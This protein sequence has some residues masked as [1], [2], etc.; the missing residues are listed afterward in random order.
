MEDLKRGRQSKRVDNIQ[1][2]FLSWV[3]FNFSQNAKFY[4]ISFLSFIIFS[5]LFFYTFL[6]LI[7]ATLVSVFRASFH[8]CQK[9]AINH[10]TCGFQ[11]HYYCCPHL[12]KTLSTSIFKSFSHCSEK[13]YTLCLGWCILFIRWWV[14]F[15]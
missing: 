7:K 2:G 11:R 9:T 15:S 8:L 3:F 13:M 4:H 12:H 14:S 5:F 6:G 10:P 1:T